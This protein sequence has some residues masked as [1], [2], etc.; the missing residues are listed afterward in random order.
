MLIT[1]AGRGRVAQWSVALTGWLLLCMLPLQ[2][3]QASGKQYVKR[4]PV[5]STPALHIS[6]QHAVTTPML[7]IARA[8]KRLVSVGEWGVILL[9]DNSGHSWR[10]ARNVPVS[11]ALTAVQFV[12]PLNGWAVGHLG[13]VLHT[14][15][16]GEHWSRQ[17]D[18]LQAAQLAL[19]AAKSAVQ[20]S[21]DSAASKKQLRQAKR[22]VAEGPDRPFLCLYF[23]NADD[24]FVLGAFGLAFHTTDGGRHWLPWMAHVDDPMGFHLYGM[25]PLGA[26]L[27]IVGE[28]GTLLYSKGDAADFT[29]MKTPDNGSWFGVLR[30]ADRAILL[31]GLVGAVY[32]SS[33]EGR[34][35]QMSDSG[36]DDSIS[37]ATNLKN[38]NIVLTT[39][40]GNVLL[41]QDDGRHFHQVAALN[42]PLTGIVQAPDGSLVVSSINGPK[43]VVLSPSK[44]GRH[45]H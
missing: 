14:Q 37:A 43:H 10:Q 24:G 29:A 40:A 5:L 9:S 12:S 18:G 23:R 2:A 8:G 44:G 17:L 13:V 11:V 19:A 26:G 22:L 31:Y 15:D 6:A 45:G 4:Y 41:S 39:V 34:H 35:W 3:V 38:G 36:T 33:D 32:R 27:L 28:Q 25:A 42:V 20:S 30:T 16:G 7:A 21:P 1:S